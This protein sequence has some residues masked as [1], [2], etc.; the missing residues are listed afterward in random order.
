M[1]WCLVFLSMVLFYMFDTTRKGKMRM[2]IFIKD[3]HF[4]SFGA[5]YQIVL[6]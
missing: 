4:A 3:G 5:I 2:P 1:M 6:Q